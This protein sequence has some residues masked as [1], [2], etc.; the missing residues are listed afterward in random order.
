MSYFTVLGALPVPESQRVESATFKPPAVFPDAADVPVVELEELVG[1]ASLIF[2]SSPKSAFFYMQYSF[3][4]PKG[5][6]ISSSCHTIAWPYCR[7]LRSQHLCIAVRSVI[8]PY[9]FFYRISFLSSLTDAWSYFTI[10]YMERL[11]QMGTNICIF[12][13]FS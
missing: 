5:V 12:P 11:Y 4:F 7:L 10:F 8:T 3:C 2:N 1:D 9:H 6:V 13:Y